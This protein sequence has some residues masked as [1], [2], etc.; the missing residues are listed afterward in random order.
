MLLL[1]KSYEEKK[2]P[3]RERCP[4][5]KKA[6]EKASRAGSWGTAI[7][8]GIRTRNQKAVEDEQPEAL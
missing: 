6:E 2:A 3:G 8:T 4:E 5:E 1:E 7:R